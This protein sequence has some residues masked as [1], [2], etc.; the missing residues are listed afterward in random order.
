MKSKGLAYKVFIKVSF[1]VLLSFVSC[2]R[3]QDS[4]KLKRIEGKQIAIDPSI[5]IDDE[6]ESFITP[7]REEIDVQMKEVIA[8]A[9]QTLDKNRDQNET[10]LGNF[11]ADLCQKR[12]QEKLTELTDKPID[13]TLLNIG[14]LRSNIDKGPVHVLNAYEVMPFENH[15][16]VAELDFQ[17][18]MDLLQYLANSDNPHPIS[19][20]LKVVFDDDQIKQALV[21]GQEIDNK[22]TYMV[23]T[24]DYLI[25]GGDNMDFFKKAKHVFA[26]D[27]LVRDALLDELIEIDTI[28]VNYDQRMV[29]Y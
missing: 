8:Y 6:L 10:L 16:V 21:N 14:G 26:L 22:R 23:L 17:T 2:K 9:P 28:K 12:A 7:F 29:R 11:M 25:N 5:D 15:L 20:S 18:T 19:K 13:F 24:N 3:S 4:L 27:Y 1:V